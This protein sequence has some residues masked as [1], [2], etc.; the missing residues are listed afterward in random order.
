MEEQKVK[1]ITRITEYLRN[2][3]EFNKALKYSKRKSFRPNA[4]IV[5][6]KVKIINH[7]ESDV[8]KKSKSE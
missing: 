5:R 7:S 3:N 8:V 2:Y 4:Y 6:G 1:I